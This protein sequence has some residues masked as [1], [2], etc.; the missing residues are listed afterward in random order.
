M[1][2]KMGKQEG[3]A[4]ESIV[5]L[6]MVLQYL[7]SIGTTSDQVAR[8]MDQ[9]EAQAIPPDQL[10]IFIARKILDPLTAG[11]ILEDSLRSTRY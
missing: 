10:G 8:T 4:Y 5:Q 3:E 9:A 6:E 2:Y 7:D 1:I 11:K